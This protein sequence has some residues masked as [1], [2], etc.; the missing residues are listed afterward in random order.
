MAALYSA[1]SSPL[2]CMFGPRNTSVAPNMSFQVARRFEELIIN[3]PT[4]VTSRRLLLHLLR[5][6]PV[7]GV[8][9]TVTRHGASLIVTM[10]RVGGRREGRLGRGL[11]D[12]PFRH[13]AGVV[14]SAPNAEDAVVVTMVMMAAA[15]VMMLMILGASPA[16]RRA[17][18]VLRRVVVMGALESV[19]AA[20]SAGPLHDRVVRGQHDKARLR[21]LAAASVWSR[22]GPFVIVTVLSTV[23]RYSSIPNFVGWVGM[24]R[25]TP[26]HWSAGS[27]RPPGRHDCDGGTIMEVH[28]AEGVSPAK[29]AY[30]AEHG[31]C[32]EGRA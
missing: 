20:C 10:V 13:A 29:S 9:V 4:R 12:V 3:L 31:S 16:M 11:F 25:A 30:N 23:C 27:C 24:H 15:M 6:H 1:Q 26:G 28:L 22:C 2:H 32:D 7:V 17:L 14:V 8:L 5:P 18:R 21:F 19:F